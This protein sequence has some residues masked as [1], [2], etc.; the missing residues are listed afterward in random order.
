VVRAHLLVGGPT[1]DVLEYFSKVLHQKL[2]NDPLLRFLSRVLEIAILPA[3]VNI[4]V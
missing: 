4:L 1:R 2:W 3:R